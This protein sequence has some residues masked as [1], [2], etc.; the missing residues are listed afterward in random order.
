[1]VLN[2]RRFTVGTAETEMKFGNVFIAS[3]IHAGND[4]RR[5]AKRGG[6]KVL[7][8]NST[9]FT[10]ILK[11]ASSGTEP[12]LPF[13]SVPATAMQTAE[14]IACQSN[15]PS[16]STLLKRGEKNRFIQLLRYFSFIQNDFTRYGKTA[17]IIIFSQTRLKL[18][19]TAPYVISP[20]WPKNKMEH[21]VVL[22]GGARTYDV[23]DGA[24][25]RIA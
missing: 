4:R 9:A 11:A 3:G 17:V 5:E 22:R 6:T 2:L 14:S 24:Y 25:V 21:Y 15:R 1:M 10:R 18:W 8:P 16:E 13:R 12:G 19:R 7:R 23:P 20:R